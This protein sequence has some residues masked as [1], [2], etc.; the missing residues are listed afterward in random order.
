MEIAGDKQ[1]KYAH[2]TP[3]STWTGFFPPVS[4][5]LT[6]AKAHRLRVNCYQNWNPAR[7]TSL[8]FSQVLFQLFTWKQSVTMRSKVTRLRRLKMRATEHLFRTHLRISSSM[9]LD[10]TSKIQ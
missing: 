8:N 10:F 2:N 9:W 3:G 1:T 4:A 6:S 5:W 7:S